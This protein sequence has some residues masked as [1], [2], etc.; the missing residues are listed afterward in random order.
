MI[1]IC[2]YL[3]S[4]THLNDVKILSAHYVLNNK[5]KKQIWKATGRKFTKV[6]YHWR[7]TGRK[8]TLGNQCPLTKLLNSRPPNIWAWKKTG[9][10]FPLGTQC[11]DNK[12]SE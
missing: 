12:P 8:F 4:S 1:K 5:R 3:S 11:A 2:T 9:R 10:T 7:P 6:G